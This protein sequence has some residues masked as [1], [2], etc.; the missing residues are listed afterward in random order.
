M[1]RNTKARKLKLPPPDS[2]PGDCGAAFGVLVTGGAVTVTV[3]VDILES[4]VPS[5]TTNSKVT[6]F[7][8]LPAL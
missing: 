1:N 3:I 7:D 2:E 5:F 6:V 4:T 8:V